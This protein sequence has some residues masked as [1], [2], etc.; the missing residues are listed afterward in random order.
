SWTA[1]GNGKE[2]LYVFNRADRPPSWHR[3]NPEVAGF[4]TTLL[5]DPSE[6]ADVVQLLRKQAALRTRSILFETNIEGEPYQVIARPVYVP[7]SRTI[8]QGIVGFTVNL[9]WVRGHYFAD[10]TAEVSRVL[11]GRGNMVL[12]VFDEKGAL[13]ASNKPAGSVPTNA[14]ASVFER[15]FPFLFFDPVLRATTPGEALPFRYWTART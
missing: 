15:K 5:K 1:E 10:L 9:N 2:V 4:P 13:I 7:H 12:E 14:Q 6:L 11:E 3:S 8:L